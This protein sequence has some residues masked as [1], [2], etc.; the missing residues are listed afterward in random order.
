MYFQRLW[1]LLYYNKYRNVLVVIVYLYNILII[2]ILFNNIRGLF[3][4][5]YI[6]RCTLNNTVDKIPSCLTPWVTLNGFGFRLKVYSPFNSEQFHL[7]I[8]FCF[9]SKSLHSCWDQTRLLVLH[10][11]RIY[12]NFPLPNLSFLVCQSKWKCVT[13]IFIKHYRFK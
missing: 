7:S 6:Y 9:T 12:I 1:R 10:I 13:T 3:I 4:N 11:R 2:M 5:L 8:S